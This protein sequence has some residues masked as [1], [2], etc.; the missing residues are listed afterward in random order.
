MKMRKI[1]F[2]IAMLGVFGLCGCSNSDN[3]TEALKKQ[4]EE[5]QKQNEELSN[6]LDEMGQKT[7]IEVTEAPEVTMTPAP[8]STPEATPEPTSTPVPTVEPTAIPTSTEVLVVEP[9]EEPMPTATPLPT[10]TPESTSTPTP[11]PTS[12]PVPT[13]TPKPTATPVPTNTPTPVPK[14]VDITYDF[15][16][17]I[18]ETSYGTDYSIGRDGSIF[19]QFKGIYQEIKLNLP[20]ILDMNYCTG[21]SVNVL[22]ENRTVSVKLYDET[23]KE[24]YVNYEAIIPNV[25]KQNYVFIPKLNSKVAG[26]GL[27][28]LDSV[29]DTSTI[30]D[31][32]FHMME[33]KAYSSTTL[34]PTATP[35]PTPT[36]DPRVVISKDEIV[37]YR[38][39]IELTEDN[40]K[41]YFAFEECEYIEKDA[42]NEYTGRELKYKV[43]VLK[44][45]YVQSM[46][47]NVLLK[48]DI[49]TA[50]TSS[51]YNS[52][53]GLEESRSDSPIQ[54]T[55]SV[56][57]T[58]ISFSYLL[59]IQEDKSS[60]LSASS[61]VLCI[62]REWRPYSMNGQRKVWLSEK[63]LVKYDIKNIKGCV[64]EWDIPEESWN[65]DE[66]GLR[67]MLVD[68][69]FEE[70][71]SY[72]KYWRYYEDGFYVKRDTSEWER[73]I[74]GWKTL[75][76]VVVEA[77]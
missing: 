73:K 71:R 51:Y 48:F 75:P 31:I 72:D 20:E 64:Y 33:G 32:T 45:P 8:T 16:D 62:I 25:G 46:F 36:P 57:V 21:V 52:E 77:W 1:F 58:P 40:W 47:D 53:T 5:L 3:E 54:R 76:D 29:D 74:S 66:N 7:E 9:T 26:I 41:D 59:S 34:K 22:S 70:H 60:S 42:F 44:E 13:T 10:A 63:E 15:D 37:S 28:A 6:K 38:K 67:Y 14:T 2:L 11:I 69:G 43:V 50:E 23:W 39:E 35:K 65:V 24:V 12:T 30:Y 56:I 27:M 19:L 55:E 17:L 18:Y 68:H 49:E 4:M 61:G